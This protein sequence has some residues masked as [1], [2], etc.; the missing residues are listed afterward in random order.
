M[1]TKQQ[2]ETEQK[3]QT[4]RRTREVSNTCV[5][6]K[7]KFISVRR[8]QCCSEQCRGI[9]RR[10]KQ[11]SGTLG[12]DYIECPAC[13]QQVK[14]ITLSHIKRHG[15]DSVQDFKNH[16]SMEKVT[17]EKIIELH[18]GENNPGY[19]HGGKFSKFSKNFIHGYDKQWHDAHSK[20]IS[21]DRQENPHKYPTSIEYWQKKY[22]DHPDRAKQEY[23]QYQTR[24]LAYFIDKYGEE[25]GRRRHREK[26]ERWQNT[27]AHK[28][29]EEKL[30]IN[31]KKVRKS[32]AFYSQA[33]KELYQS[34]KEIIPELDDQF[35]L[36][37]D[38]E[39][40]NKQVYLYDMK[41]QDRI[42]EYNGDFWHSN[43]DLFES[44]HVCPYT[45]RTQAEIHAK[46]FD[47]IRIAKKHGYH[48][49]TV[50]ESD[51]KKHKQ[52]VIQ[53]CLDFLTK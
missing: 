30:E 29:L 40:H 48:V 22:P 33:E 4:S 13:K 42:I 52:K 25:E 20:R 39:S 28:P 5:I 31:R 50:W 44:D 6:C 35:A 43:P 8:S 46:D 9:R 49:L 10:N 51:Y 53:E 15:F 12:K 24:D 3:N 7:T 47:K 21:K 45:K 2:K 41:F 37:V 17:C 16:Y 1:S 27:L 19:Q 36:P 26:I 14:Q 18:S 23:A 32:S 38:E 11:I 34:L